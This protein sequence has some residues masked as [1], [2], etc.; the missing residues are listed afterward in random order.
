MKKPTKPQVGMGDLVDQFMSKY[1]IKIDTMDSDDLDW[2]CYFIGYRGV[3]EN[4]SLEFFLNDNPKV[5]QYILDYIV[6]NADKNWKDSFKR[7]LTE[8]DDLDL[9]E[10]EG[11]QEDDISNEQ[12]Y[13]ICTKVK[14]FWNAFYHGS[15]TI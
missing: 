5:L 4:K 15:P 10:K 11:Y 7:S 3:D 2:L 14:R 6:A 1:D 9:E 8:F 13:T 12:Q